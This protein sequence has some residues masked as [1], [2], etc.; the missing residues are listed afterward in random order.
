MGLGVFRASGRKRAP[1]PPA[2]ISALTTVPA[3]VF[4]KNNHYITP[5]RAAIA[6]KLGEVP[7]AAL[8][9]PSMKMGCDA[10]SSRGHGAVRLKGGWS[11]PTALD[12]LQGST[13]SWGAAPG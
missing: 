3:P 10:C 9:H 6:G 12:H 8:A 5:E 13:F 1:L 2:S 4:N 7:H 11:G